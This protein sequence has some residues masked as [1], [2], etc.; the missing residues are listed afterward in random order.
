MQEHSSKGVVFEKCVVKAAAQSEIPRFNLPEHSFNTRAMFQRSFPKER[1]LHMW[2]RR[3]FTIGDSTLPLAHLQYKNAVPTELLFLK[4]GAEC[5][6][7]SDTQHYHVQQ[8]TFNTSTLFRR[9]CFWNMWGRRSRTI[10]YST[11]PLATAHIEYV[12][13]GQKVLHNRI[14]HNTAC[15]SRPSIQGHCSKGVVSK[16]SLGPKAPPNRLR[17]QSASKITLT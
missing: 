7:Q 14:L 8:R 16:T 2:G 12:H 11:L 5:P 9:S 6:A 3:P 10:G 4:C 1:F 17:Q 15:K 13:V